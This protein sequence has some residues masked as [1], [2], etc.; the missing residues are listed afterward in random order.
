VQ[1]AACVP[2][3][4]VPDAPL[5]GIDA[6]LYFY[7]AP[8]AAIASLNNDLIRLKLT[9][10]EAEACRDHALRFLSSVFG[11]VFVPDVRSPPASVEWVCTLLQAAFEIDPLHKKFMM[12]LHAPGKRVVWTRPGLEED[13]MER[14]LRDHFVN[15]GL[16]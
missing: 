8:R 1:R 4:R 6:P 2:A 10:F 9:P 14:L 13:E 16:L 15:K 12:S 3:F 7:G 11:V 5:R